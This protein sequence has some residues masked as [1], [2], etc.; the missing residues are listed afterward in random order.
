M[1]F[2]G[3]FSYVSWTVRQYNCVYYCRYFLLNYCSCNFRGRP[4]IEQISRLL[5]AIAGLP[6][7]DCLFNSI[8][9]FRK[10]T[11]DKTYAWD[12]IRC[13][14]ITLHLVIE[15]FER[16]EVRK[17]LHRKFEMGQWQTNQIN[18]LDI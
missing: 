8:I 16:S 1:T 6:C 17:N 18:Y 5:S 4:T 12:R 7:Y 2:E 3:N 10:V 11:I 14:R 9:A 15:D 13:R